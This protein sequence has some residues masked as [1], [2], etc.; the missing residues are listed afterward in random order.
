MARNIGMGAASVPDEGRTLLMSGHSSSKMDAM[1]RM[2]L[3]EGP[4]KERIRLNKDVE[5]AIV[6]AATWTMAAVPHAKSPSHWR[7]TKQEGLCTFSLARL[8]LQQDAVLRHDL[9]A[10]DHVELLRLAD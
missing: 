2:S 8:A 4:K 7:S 9:P 5:G 10:L 3:A 1:Y 6:M